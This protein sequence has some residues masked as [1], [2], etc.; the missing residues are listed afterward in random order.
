MREKIIFIWI[1]LLFAFIFLVLTAYSCQRPASQNKPGPG[2]SGMS[3]GELIDKGNASLME[4]RPHE[5]GPFFEEELRRDPDSIEARI[6]LAKVALYD[7]R[8]QDARD[9]LDQA[10]KRKPGDPFLRLK[11][12]DLLV[13]MQRRMDARKIYRDLISEGNPPPE[14][15]IGYADILLDNDRNQ[16]AREAIEKAIAA[17]P[18]LENSRAYSLLARSYYLDHKYTEARDY[19]ERAVSATPR[20]FAPRI[21]YAIFLSEQDDRKK[22][23]VILNEVLSEIPEND[24]TSRYD[25]F[26]G[27]VG[28]YAWEGDMEKVK[29]NF[30]KALETTQD[31]SAAYADLG[32]RLKDTRHHKE[33]E[34]ALKESI[35]LDPGNDYA[36][37]LLAKLLED[38]CR[39]E[40]ATKLFQ[41][42]GKSSLLNKMYLAGTYYRDKQWE[43]AEKTYREIVYG[44]PVSQWNEDHLECVLRLGEILAD[45]KRFKEAW[46]LVGLIGKYRAEATPMHIIKGRIYFNAGK[47][48]EAETEYRRTVELCPTEPEVR[49]YIYLGQLYILQKRYK[50]AEE[51]FLEAHKYIP[52]LEQPFIG[53]LDLYMVQGRLEEASRV[54]WDHLSRTSR[55]RVAKDPAY[56]KLVESP[57]FRK[58]QGK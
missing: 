37:E 17:D 14:A 28:A 16:Q 46:K 2:F 18:K 23:I 52:Y 8:I 3:S 1:A 33:A 21:E 56:V 40:E 5:A 27:L 4:N 57:Y 50:E 20:L 7:K 24:L 53:L 55:E 38:A 34:A 35:K 22:G 26:M 41:R 9:L 31:K 36:I 49:G 11:I 39:E 48:K 44:V 47:W 30:Q 42:L 51:A 54:Y 25:A 15:Y 43:K 13:L 45:T 6:G 32:W 19:F 10:I 29:S 58:E 12:A